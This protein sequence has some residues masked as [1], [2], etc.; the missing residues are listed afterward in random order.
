[1]HISSQFE[2]CRFAVV[3]VRTNH[4]KKFRQVDNEQKVIF[5]KEGL[6]LPP[7]YLS[8]KTFVRT[9]AAQPNDLCDQILISSQHTAPGYNKY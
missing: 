2:R 3:C 5:C 1:M 9:S 6:C 7:I 4:I 8:K